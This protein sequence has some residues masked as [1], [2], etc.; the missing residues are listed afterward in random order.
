MKINIVLGLVAIGLIY[1]TCKTFTKKTEEQPVVAET[2]VTPNSNVRSASEWKA[3]H[4]LGSNPDTA[5]SVQIHEPPEM[6]NVPIGAIAP[7][8]TSRRAYLS[9]GWWHCSMAYSGSDT[10]VHLNYQQKWLKFRED[11]TF[12][13]MIKGKVVDNT[14][15]WA[16]D[17]DK[18]QIFLSCKD[19]YINNSWQVQ[20]KGFVMILKGNT[21]INFTGIQVR[22]ACNK[23]QPN[24]N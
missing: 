19:P 2:L 7:P 1:V 16:F 14:G 23:T 15:R 24:W 12:D 9:T 10:L 8:N 20:D 5:G 17:E 18:N 22:L 3:A 11:Q 21:D 13:V 6:V 4:V